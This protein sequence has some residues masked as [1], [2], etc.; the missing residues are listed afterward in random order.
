MEIRV[1][2]CNFHP[3]EFSSV[4]EGVREFDELAHLL[5]GNLREGSDGLHCA[6]AAAI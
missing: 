4:L 5:C 1:I 3:S 6:A 2:T